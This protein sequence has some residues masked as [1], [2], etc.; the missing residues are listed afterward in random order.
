[1]NSDELRNEYLRF[2]ESKK[3]VVLPSSSLIPIGDPTLL[4]TSA[5][6]VQIKPFFT[7]DAVPP[8][9]RLASCQ[10]CFRATDIDSVGD[11]DHLTFFEMLGNFSVADYFKR[12]AIEWAWEFSIERLKIPPERI[13]ASVFL[14]DD[15]SHQYWLDM[16]VPAERIVRYDEAENWWGPPGD[17]GPCGPCTELYYDFGEEYACGKPD[18]GPACDCNR[19]TEYWNLVLTEYYQDREGNRTLLPNGNIDTGMGVE[20]TAAILQ[21]VTNVYQADPF[22]EIMESVSRLTGKTYGE[23]GETDAAMRVLA[24]HGR[25]ITFLIADGVVPSNEG[26]GYVLR[27][28]LRRAVTFARKLGV[29][30][31]VLPEIAQTVMQKMGAVYPELVQNRQFIL[32]VIENEES[33]FHHTLEAGLSLL[34]DITAEAARNKVSV[35]SGADAFR[36]YDTYGFPAEL[37]EEVAKEQGFSVDADGFRQEMESQRQRGRAA[38]TFKAHLTEGETY[39][40]L[41]LGATRFTGYEAIQGESVVVGLLVE[42]RSV[43]RASEGDE[44]E[45]ITVETPFYS[46]G[47][48]Q[49]GDRGDVNGPQGLLGVE[50][51]Q[52]TMPGLITHKGSVKNGIIAIG[53]PVSMRVDPTHRRDATRNHTGTHLLHAALRKVLGEHVRQGGSLVTPNRLRFDFTHPVGLS[54]AEL[55][56]VKKLTNEQ[57]RA[58]LAVSIDEMRYADAVA[59]GALAF[60]GD[61]YGETV[62]VVEMG[63]EDPFSYEVC[64]GTHVAYTGEVWY[65]QVVDEGSI[66]SG[67][68]RIEA[69]TG[70][71]AQEMVAERFDIVD[72]LARD[73]NTTP[74]ELPE[75]I[76]ALSEDLESERKRAGNLERG[77]ARQEAEELV[78]QVQQVDGVSLVAARVKAPNVESM[79]EMGD[80]LKDRLNSVVIVLASIINQRP[81]FVTMVTPDLVDRGIHAGNIAKQ[82]AAA[83]GGGGGGRPELAQAGGK[84]PSKIGQ[85][86]EAVLPAIRGGKC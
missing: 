32:K 11:A 56:D 39:G 83:T 69:V 80:L 52:L 15:E 29:E 8:A 31:P 22:K 60:F 9:P 19:F 75:R 21:G 62:R 24:E 30:E 82:V 20:R 34:D 50:D 18:C 5:G 85:A 35:V 61:K 47:G 33:R 70:V 86:L 76:A 78:G 77:L 67:L 16:G 27:R 4:L 72:S 46:E 10:K 63:N 23:S 2:F 1:M 43:E 40:S 71:V 58:D 64:G 25:S 28:I 26:R 12:E 45:V 79:R 54:S 51:T 3:H 68:R 13:W 66:G 41:G 73:L 44:A 65:L 59:S 38:Q 55:T 7:G 84:D 36:L 57:V 17:E 42:G 49:V 81:M 37:T 74:A 48:G 53:D 6:V 14:D